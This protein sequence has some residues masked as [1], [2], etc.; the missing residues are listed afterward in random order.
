MST[1]DRVDSLLKCP[2]GEGKVCVTECSPDHPYAKDSQTW[3]TAEIMCETCNKKY[4]LDDSIIDRDRYIILRPNKP[5]DPL[6]K[7]RKINLFCEGL[8]K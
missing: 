4:Q 6:V 5:E 7:I 3:Y 1:T 2:C 8:T